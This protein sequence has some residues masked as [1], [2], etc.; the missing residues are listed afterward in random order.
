MPRDAAAKR[1]CFTINNYTTAE[2]DTLVDSADNFDYLCF[3]RE[4]GDNNTP[5]LQGYVV[6]KQ[7]LRLANV[8]AL[9][10]FQRSHLEVSRGTPLQASD[11][12]K[13]EGDYSEFGQLPTGQ[14]RRTDFEELKEWI[15]IQDERPTD[16]MLAEEFPSLWGRYRSACIS[17]RELFSAQPQLVT[18]NLRTWQNNLDVLVNEPADDRTVHFLV[19][20]NGNSGKSWL[21]RHW[22]SSRPDDVQMFT[23][24]KRDDLAYAVDPDKSLFVFDVPRGGMQ[25]LQYTIL[26]QLKNRVVFSPKYDSRVK[27]L[28][29]NC[30]VVV[31]SNEEPDRDKMS[32]DRYKV[33][34]IR[35]L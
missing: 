1:W 30:H 4:R 7:K 19:D 14:G 27:I 10:G 6:L 32:R 8:K 33:T 24:A 28:K 26:E 17:F 5:H 2:L 25:F 23:I 20:E 22:F 34:H 15:K 16:R 35:R 13:K 11:Y 21:T 29:K 12:C 9:P 31:F 3:G 18:G